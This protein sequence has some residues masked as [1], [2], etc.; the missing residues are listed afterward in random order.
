MNLKEWKND[1]NIQPVK[2]Y[3]ILTIKKAENTMIF[4]INGTIV[5]QTE[6][7][8]FYGPFL[9]FVLNKEIKIK[10]V[11]KINTSFLKKK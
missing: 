11:E 9:G 7:K 10:V 5:F 8:N 1:K 3:N 6:F 2:N 4:L